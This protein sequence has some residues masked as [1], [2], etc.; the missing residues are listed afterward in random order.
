M[1]RYNTLFHVTVSFIVLLAALP[2]PSAAQEADTSCNGRID[3]QKLK[4][5]LS[6]KGSYVPVKRSLRAER[7][8]LAGKLRRS[9]PD[10][11]LY[12][13]AKT[14][15]EDGIINGLIPFWYGTEWD[16]YGHTSVPNQGVIACGYFVSTVLQHAGFILNRYTLAQQGGYNEARSI[17]TDDSVQIY[18]SRFDGFAQAFK[19]KNEEGLYFVGLDCH[20]GFLLYRAGELFFIHSSYM[21]PLCVVVEKASLSVPFNATT[22]YTVAALSTN[23]KLIEKWLKK[24]RVRIRKDQ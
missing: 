18:R 9:S 15:L 8:A 12:S 16:F 1:E 22:T 20:V 14:A 19:K 7:N 17:Q 6:P 21:S 13:R 23:R 2:P 10:D 24:E 5:R 3:T 11:T 4:I